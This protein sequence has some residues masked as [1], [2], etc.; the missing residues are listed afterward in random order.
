MTTTAKHDGPEASP[1]TRCSA[2]I[3][4][5]TV[6]GLRGMA[7]T[8]IEGFAPLT[9]IVGRNGSRKSTLLEAIHLATAAD[10]AGALA[11]MVARRRG[12]ANGVRWI[13]PFGET[14]G[15]SIEVEAQRGPDRTSTRFVATPVPDEATTGMLTANGASPP[16]T[17]I[18]LESET[19][20]EG[21]EATSR[22]AFLSFASDGECQY[23]YL[24]RARMSSPFAHQVDILTP[25]VSPPGS[26]ADAYTALRAAGRTKFADRVLA[27]LADRGTAPADASLTIGS[28][29]GRSF[30]MFAQADRGVPIAVA[31][32]GARELIESAV[33]YAQ[34]DDGLALHEEPELHLHPG[35]QRCLAGLMADTV[36]RG[37]QV[38][39]TTHSLELIDDLLAEFSDDLASLAVITTSLVAGR[40]VTTTL[41]GEAADRLRSQIGEDLR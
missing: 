8:V 23:K 40:L 34:Y 7:E 28:E 27:T 4:K 6:R 3:E 13:F 36:R 26:L 30:L 25:G 14:A 37:R 16:F 29:Q 11:M 41:P 22:L 18:R 10:S 38:V 39:L 12:V 19:Q 2:V 31:G 32:D 5:L 20:L 21:T 35:A 17:S 9:I 24:Q 1:P 15:T 33:Y